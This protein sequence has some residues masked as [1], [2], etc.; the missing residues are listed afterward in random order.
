MICLPQAILSCQR[1][2]NRL[3]KSTHHNSRT[4]YNSAR[5]V[6]HHS[7]PQILEAVLDMGS[8][9]PHSRTQN[10]RKAVSSEFLA[11]FQLRE[12]SSSPRFLHQV[13]PVS[14]ILNR[15]QKS[16]LIIWRHPQSSRKKNFE[17]SLSAGH[18][19]SLP[20]P[21]RSDSRAC[22]AGRGD[23]SS[24]YIRTSKKLW[25]RFIRVWPHNDPTKILPS[26]K[27]EDSGNHHKIWT[28]FPIY[29]TAPI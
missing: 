24:S 4:D 15:R 12:N 26:H 3:W 5:I 8:S 25:K 7:K 27:F 21:W 29:P 18:G 20:G 19:H 28:V 1:D 22:D 17:K 14:I 23:N 6:L 10:W 13:K 16:T 2:N 11:R 9:E